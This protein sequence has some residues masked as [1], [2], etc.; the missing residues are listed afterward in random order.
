VKDSIS[1]F[2]Q[3]LVPRL[4]AYNKRNRLK[5]MVIIVALATGQPANFL[6]KIDSKDIDNWF[7][8]G[9]V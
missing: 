5:V 9:Q 4:N 6:L 2:V 3:L 1:A 7:I 8:E